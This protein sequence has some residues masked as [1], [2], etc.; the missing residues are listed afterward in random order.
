MEGGEEMKYIRIRSYYPDGTFTSCEHLYNESNQQKA[1]E[2]FR[3]DYPEHDECIIV[4]EDYDS[5]AEENKEHFRICKEC[6][7]VHFF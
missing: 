3:K 2:R 6:V 1:L 7:C 4:A 5:D